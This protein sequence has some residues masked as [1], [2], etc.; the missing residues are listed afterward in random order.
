MKPIFVTATGTE[1]G[2][3]YIAAELVRQLRAAGRSVDAL[4]P[5]LSGFEMEAAAES[6]AG[7]LLAAL[8]REITP[9]TLNRITPWRFKAALSPDMAAEREGKA[10]DY[11]ALVALCRERAAGA[12]GDLVIE[13]VGGVMVPLDDRHTVLDWIAELKPE[14][15]LVAGSYLGTISHTLTALAALSSRGLVPRAIVLSES[16]E[17]PVPMEETMR[18]IGR[19]SDVPAIAVPRG[20]PAPSLLGL[21]PDA[22]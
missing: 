3:T 5:V 21:A 22:E 7:H 2:K 14:I 18:A 4:K 8:G 16:I 10:I 17:S 13:G 6:D 11:E 9:E 1:I 15:L 20:S 12:G 19:Y